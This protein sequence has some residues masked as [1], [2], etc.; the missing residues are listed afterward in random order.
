MI[1][2]SLKPQVERKFLKLSVV[3]DLDYGFV[4]C[5]ALDVNL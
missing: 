1:A 2:W 3:F 5:S 4:I